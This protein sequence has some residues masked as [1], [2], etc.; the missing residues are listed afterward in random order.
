MWR[1][2]PRWC[3][4]Y[5][6]IDN[7]PTCLRRPASATT[8]L[9][10]KSRLLR[11]VKPVNWIMM[12]TAYEDHPTIHTLY[13]KIDSVLLGL[14]ISLS[15]ARPIKARRTEKQPSARRKN[16]SRRSTP[17]FSKPLTCEIR[18]IGCRRGIKSIRM[19]EKRMS[20]F[21]DSNW[22]H[23]IQLKSRQNH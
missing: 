20:A 19:R 21:R 5:S 15:Y 8:I 7:V 2:W 18:A 10:L 9:Y 22:Q 14:E 12:K 6:E 23:F 16:K 17:N 4:E 13:L 3:A 11:K 1:K